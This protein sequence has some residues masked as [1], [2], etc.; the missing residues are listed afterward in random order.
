MLERTDIEQY[1]AV[2]LDDGTIGYVIEIFGDGN[3]YMVEYPKPDR[4]DPYGDVI[5]TREHILK[6]LGHVGDHIPGLIN[7]YEY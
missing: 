1:D 4:R 3:A 7:P 5:I 6:V 2:L